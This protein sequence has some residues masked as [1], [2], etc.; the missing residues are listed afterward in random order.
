MECVRATGLADESP[1]RRVIIDTERVSFGDNTNGFFFFPG[2]DAE[3]LVMTC[4]RE[5]DQA[6]AAEMFSRNVVLRIY[7]HT[8]LTVPLLGHINPER[9]DQKQRNSFGFSAMTEPTQK[10]CQGEQ[11]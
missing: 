4:A 5:R 8:G 9:G 11:T 3:R 2:G 1:R 6:F 10:K 7:I